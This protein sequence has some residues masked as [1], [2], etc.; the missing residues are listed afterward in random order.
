MQ[1]VFKRSK[2]FT[3]WLEAER[4]DRRR[5]S[6]HQPRRRSAKR[7]EV[8]LGHGGTLDPIATGVLIVGVGKGT[9]QLKNFLECAKAYEATVLFGAATD[10]YD[11]AGKT[12]GKA[13][14]SQVT[15][16]AVGRALQHFR[17]KNMQ[18][19]PTYSALRFQGKRFY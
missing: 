14:Y 18:K 12:I 9:K 11:T 2:F 10:T 19:P 5:L 1:H 13:P 7:V 4:A 15:E 16:D 8:K 3:P 6:T 17:G